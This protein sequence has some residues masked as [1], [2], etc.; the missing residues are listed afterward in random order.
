MSILRFAYDRGLQPVPAF[1][2]F[3][4]IE[5]FAADGLRYQLNYLLWALQIAQCHYTPNFHGYLNQAQRNLLDKMT[6]PKVW[7][8]WR[9]ENFWGNFS[10][11]PDPIAKDNIMFG[12]FSATNVALYTANTGDRHY[13]EDGSLTFR[14]N[15]RTAFRHSLKTMMD[16]GRWNHRNAVY[17]PM[18]PC[19]PNMTYS[20]CN[21]WGNYQFM[22]G[23]RI[24]GT[25]EM[26][27][28]LPKL[29]VGQVSEML[30]A[31]GMPIG[32]RCGFL[33][34]RII[35]NPMKSTINVVCQWGWQAATFFPDLAR[36]VW[37]ILRREVIRRDADGDAEVTITPFDRLD[38]A[39]FKKH[40]LHVYAHLLV[41]ARELGDEDTADALLRKV[42]K[43]YARSDR[44]GTTS[45]PRAA[46]VTH[47]LMAM[48]RLLRRG[49]LRTLH[50]DG[51]PGS[52]MRGP[53]LENAS[54]PQV[55]VAKAWSH[56]GS[57]LE[58]VLEPGT[59]EP[60]QR[61]GLSR[62]QPCATYVVRSSDGERSVDA[63]AQGRATIELALRGRTRLV[64]EPRA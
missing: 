3:D 25:D 38:P 39:N 1:N 33:G 43:T 14:L 9:W 5:Q 54:Y 7:T 19:E 52:C 26:R 31:D 36:R 23:D 27:D 50:R 11:N 6:V 13:L 45:Y 44:D 2:G 51:P 59:G 17:A 20:V 62:L 56:R 60:V 4:V 40:T 48:G 57:D 61:L 32:G 10:L 41:M 15:E 28:L 55:L 37:A 8:W 21:L 22:I 53:L 29:R 12:G 58:L 47:A 30:S 63:D 64:I 46:T 16:V 49:D 35:G 24:F 42:A 34:T 18:Y